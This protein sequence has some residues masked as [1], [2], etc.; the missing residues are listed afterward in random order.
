VIEGVE[1]CQ[2]EAAELTTQKESSQDLP[3]PEQVAPEDCPDPLIAEPLGTL[4][5]LCSCIKGDLSVLQDICSG[6]PSD[7]LFA[8]VL[9]NIGHHRIS[10]L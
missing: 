9:T 3:T 1:V 8:K 4:P 2:C 7:L 6:Y 10:R 5:D